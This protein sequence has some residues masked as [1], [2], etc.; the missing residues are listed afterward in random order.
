MYAN[1]FCFHLWTV[2]LIL[3]SNLHIHLSTKYLC[4]NIA[5]HNLMSQTKFGLSSCPKSAPFSVS[6]SKESASFVYS[7]TSF[8]IPLPLMPH[9]QSKSSWLFLWL[10]SRMRHILSSLP[11]L[12]PPGLCSYSVSLVWVLQLSLLHP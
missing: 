4:S 6:P 5:I 12:F 3:V 9:F 7:L 1:D 8:F 10:V 11:L 2:P